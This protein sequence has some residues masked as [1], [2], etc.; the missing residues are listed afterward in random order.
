[1]TSR[2][3]L[4][5]AP[6]FVAVL[7][8]LACAV[9]PPG[10]PSSPP[11]PGSPV[12][13]LRTLVPPAPDPREDEARSRWEEAR[14]AAYAPRRI[15][16]LFR[17]E[18]SA[19]AGALVRGYLTVFWDG[20]TLLWRTSAPLAGGIAAGAVIAG[21]EGVVGS[22]FPGRLAPS[23]AV[24]A[25]LGVFDL[26]AGEASV[27]ADGDGWR[28]SFPGGRSARLDAGGR[29]RSL[30]LPGES[31]VSLEPGTGLPRKIQAVGPEG[32]ARL[33]LE[34]LGPWPKGESAGV[35]R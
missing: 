28:F 10:P 11:A 31:R 4:L 34:S 20:R 21:G 14:L 27:A 3:G 30:E 5:L 33:D 25:L 35:P 24:A 15:K 29:V 7:L 18:A 1:M 6:A 32:R 12:G 26:P 8:S 19:S 13:G 23:D 17:G 2:G 16:A 9:R 22:P